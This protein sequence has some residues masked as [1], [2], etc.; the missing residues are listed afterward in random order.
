MGSL[1]ALI[2]LL[3]VEL[4]LVL[5]ACRHDN[6]AVTINGIDS[7]ERNNNDFSIVSASD[8]FQYFYYNI[9]ECSYVY[10]STEERQSLIFGVVHWWERN[11]L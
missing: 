5:V 9:F 10:D 4:V 2:K 3:A 1:Q 11:A 7:K 6:L 8:I